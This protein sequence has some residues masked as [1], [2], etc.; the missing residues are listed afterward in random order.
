MS[1]FASVV[2]DM[3]STLASVEGIDWLASRRAP[4]VAF[5]ITALTERAMNGELTLDEVYGE[6]FAIIR[7]TERE[8]GELARLYES[9]V[10]PGAPGVLARLRAAG[11][12]LR[13]VSG[14]VLQAILPVARALGFADLEVHAVRLQFDAGGEY[15]GFDDASPLTTQLGKAE[16]VQS[17]ALPRPILAVGDGSTDAALVRVADSF[18]AYTGFV[19]REPVV[20]V[21]DHEVRSF[22]AILRLVLA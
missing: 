14:G 17:L 5:E 7:P 11:V 22:D 8:I 4:A 20:A 13:I 6:R 10:A 16:L 15:A 9:S 19:R 12:E 1:A 3:D 18:A 2:L 21:A